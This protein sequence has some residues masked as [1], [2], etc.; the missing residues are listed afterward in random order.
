VLLTLTSM[1]ILVKTTP[2]STAE[3]ICSQLPQPHP[4][5]HDYLKSTD[6]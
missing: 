5:C 3:R 2:Q 4:D 1:S 6:H